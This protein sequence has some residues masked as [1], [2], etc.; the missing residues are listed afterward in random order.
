MVDHAARV[1]DALVRHRPTAD[2]VLP[3][4]T[5]LLSAFAHQFERAF[6]QRR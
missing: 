4:A 6:G 3:K 5:R 2:T 1:G